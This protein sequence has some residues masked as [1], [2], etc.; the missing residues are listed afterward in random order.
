MRERAEAIPRT[1][2]FLIIDATLAQERSRRLFISC[3]PSR[4]ERCWERRERENV[5]ARML[6]VP[7]SVL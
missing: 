2:L 5:R 6:Y 7:E 3:D 4:R 1:V